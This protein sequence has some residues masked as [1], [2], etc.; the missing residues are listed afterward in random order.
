MMSADK[1]E[2]AEKTIL[3]IE[4]TQKSIVGQRK[5]LDKLLKGLSA[6]CRV[7]MSIFSN[8]VVRSAKEN[9]LKARQD[10]AARELKPEDIL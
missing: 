6:D 3:Q 5:K 7:S 9:I 4:A 10:Q 1:I 2:K 8:S